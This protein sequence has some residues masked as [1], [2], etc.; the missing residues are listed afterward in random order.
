MATT[1]QVVGADLAAVSTHETF[2]F[3]NLLDHHD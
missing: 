2:L 3:M 1:R